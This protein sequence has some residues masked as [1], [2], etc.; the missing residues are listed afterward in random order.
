S[1]AGVQ[2]HG[3]DWGGPIA[4]TPMIFLHGCGGN[5]W[6]F[7]ALAPL[8]RQSLGD[9]FHFVASDQRGGGDSDQPDGDY[10]PDAMS[11][12]TLAIQDQLGGRPMVLVGH[13]RGGW[14]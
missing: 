8:L 14:L 2:L 9:R 3:L 12:D 1:A 7:G 10:S 6:S 11:Q 4:A 5:G 13:S